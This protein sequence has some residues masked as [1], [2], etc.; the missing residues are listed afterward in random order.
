MCE[1]RSIRAIKI[2]LWGE[3]LNVREWLLE[4]EKSELSFEETFMK[5]SGGGRVVVMV[6]LNEG[7]LEGEFLQDRPVVIYVK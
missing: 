7:Q 4:S 1:P 3:K 5:L 2:L 6:I